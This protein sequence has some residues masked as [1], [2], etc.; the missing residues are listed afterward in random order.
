M[1]CVISEIIE[2][3]LLNNENINIESLFSNYCP[4]LH[5]FNKKSL[6]RDIYKLDK[7]SE[8]LTIKIESCLVDNL[9]LF[10]TDVDLSEF[11]H[12]FNS[13]IYKNKDELNGAIFSDLTYRFKI[14]KVN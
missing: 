14:I 7:N 13:I 8:N 10:E 2:V 4:K 6:N 12:E 11:N 1:F 9:K 3:K 5:I